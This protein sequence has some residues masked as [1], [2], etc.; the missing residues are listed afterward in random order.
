MLGKPRAL[1]LADRLIRAIDQGLGTVA[2]GNAAAPAPRPG[3]GRPE[4]AAARAAGRHAAGLMRVNHAGEI[5]AQALYHGQALTAR[6]PRVRRV[7]EDAAREETD[8]LAWCEQRV[9][10]LDRRAR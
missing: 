3:R 10:E 2:A 7:F 8:H 1:S 4:A 5:A 9:R 6:D